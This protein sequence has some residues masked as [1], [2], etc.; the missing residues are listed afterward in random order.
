MGY[1]IPFHLTEVRARSKSYVKRYDIKTT[2][3]KK[4]RRDIMSAE[5]LSFN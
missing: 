5:L 2:G 3:K 1:S 4:E